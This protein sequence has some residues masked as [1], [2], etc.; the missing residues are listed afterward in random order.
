[1][2]ILCLFISFLCITIGDIFAKNWVLTNSSLC[3]IYTLISYFCG[4]MAYLPVMKAKGLI[5]STLLWTL[6]T[7]IVGITVGLVFG[8]IITKIKMLGILLGII[9]ILLLSL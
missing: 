5:I 7:I 4:S 9:S 6:G 2:L 3:Y 8:E 1:M